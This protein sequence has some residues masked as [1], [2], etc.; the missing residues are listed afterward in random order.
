MLHAANSSSIFANRHRRACQACNNASLVAIAISRGLDSYSY[1]SAS[2]RAIRLVPLATAVE[3]DVS[4]NQ[5]IREGSYEAELVHQQVGDDILSR[6]P[7]RHTWAQIQ[8]H[9]EQASKRD[10]G[11]ASIASVLPAPDVSKLYDTAIVGAGPAGLFLA[12]E[13]GKRSLSVVVVGECWCTII[14]SVQNSF[15]DTGECP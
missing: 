12:A 14:F 6:Y 3:T 1:P 13:L 2:R 15:S 9:L 5:A 8:L 7:D 4:S 10:E 11:Q